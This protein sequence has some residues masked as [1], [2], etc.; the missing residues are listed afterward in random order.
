MNVQSENN[1]KNGNYYSNDTSSNKGLKL[2]I[3][4]IGPL[5]LI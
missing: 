5:V 3:I 1:A 2:S 4:F